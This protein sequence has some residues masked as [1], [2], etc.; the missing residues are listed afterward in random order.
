MKTVSEAVGFSLHFDYEANQ[1][2]AEINL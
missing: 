2:V 1:W